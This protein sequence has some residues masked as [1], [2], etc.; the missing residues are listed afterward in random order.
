VEAVVAIEV[1]DMDAARRWY[2]SEAYQ[3]VKKVR[4]GAADIQIVLVDGG[5]VPPDRRMPH[6][7]GTGSKP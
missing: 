2:K 7:K 4:D 5:V 3:A 6:L 1:P